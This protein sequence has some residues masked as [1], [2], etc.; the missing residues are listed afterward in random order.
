MVTDVADL[1]IRYPDTRS[2]NRHVA[3]RRRR[4]D[5]YVNPLVRETNDEGDIVKWEH[6][7]WTPA[8]RD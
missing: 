1:S 4:V 7:R 5:R 8:R 2:R 3:G 6:G